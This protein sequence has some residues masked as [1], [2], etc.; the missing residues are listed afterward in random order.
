VPWHGLPA[1][2]EISIPPLAA[3]WLTPE[4]AR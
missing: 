2:A 4:D 1:S 3:L